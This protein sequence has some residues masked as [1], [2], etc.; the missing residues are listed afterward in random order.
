VLKQIYFSLN[1]STLHQSFDLRAHTLSGKL[2]FLGN[3]RGFS[4]RKFLGNFCLKFGV[5]RGFFSSLGWQPWYRCL[6]IKLTDSDIALFRGVFFIEKRI[7]YFLHN[8]FTGYA[9]LCHISAFRVGTAAL[10]CTSSTFA[11]WP[12][13]RPSNSKEAPQKCL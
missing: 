7:L 12:N 13:F 5:F 1:T 10:L 8:Y 4:A 3:F 6:A 9:H 2:Q 11:R